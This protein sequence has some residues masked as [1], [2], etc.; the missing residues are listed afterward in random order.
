MRSA[1]YASKNSQKQKVNYLANYTCVM[2]CGCATLS[3][4]YSELI[5]TN[6]NT[7]IIIL[8]YKTCT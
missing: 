7:A 4:R 2:I 3:A 1:R 6:D 5:I 8:T